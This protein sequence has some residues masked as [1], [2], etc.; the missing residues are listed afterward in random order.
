MTQPEP[1][2]HEWELQNVCET[3]GAREAASL[4]GLTV[5]RLARALHAIKPSWGTRYCDEKATAILAAL[6]EGETP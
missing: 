5:E 6:R 2:V 4:D 3:C 1:H